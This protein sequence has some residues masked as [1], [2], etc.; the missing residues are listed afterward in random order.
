LLTY[1]RAGIDGFFTDQAD[2]G[3][4]ARAAFLRG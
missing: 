2:V 1:L 3:V 4:S